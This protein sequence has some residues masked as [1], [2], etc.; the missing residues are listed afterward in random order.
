MFGPSFRIGSIAGIAIEIHP[1]WFLVIGYLTWALAEFV[2]PDFF[3]TWATA[4]YWIIGALTAL[5][6]FVTV[7][8]H[9]LAH[10]LVAKRRGLEVPK[11]SLFIFGGVSHLGGQ[12]RTAGEEFAIAAAGPATSIVIAVAMGVGWL[13][14]HTL[15]EQL[16]AV[17]GY[18]AA[19]NILLA[20]FNMV[21]GLP[22]DGGRVLRSIAW[23]RTRSFRRATRIAAGAGE[24]VG[25][26][27]IAGGVVW[28]LSLNLV[29]IIWILMGWFLLGAARAES[30]AVQM[31]TLL[32]RL[33]A[34]DVMQEGFP[35]VT[36]GLAV[37]EVVDDQMVGRG[38]RAIMVAND[39][40]VVGIITVTDVGRVPRSDW[41]MTPAQRVMTPRSEI[42]TV[43][44]TTPA[45]DVMQVLGQKRL[46]QV[47]VLEDGR[48]IGLIT[49]REFMDRIRLAEA[50]QRDEERPEGGDEPP[51]IRMGGDGFR[52]R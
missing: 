3:E 28:L 39:G 13:L 14:F 50:L 31:D 20:A 41:S 42:V 26:L 7:L 36:P 17:L 48:M 51:P 10:A 37:Q 23:N 46:N 33:T 47:P 43:E 32:G 19:I 18:L 40:Y 2:F 34:R 52:D 1:S 9:E 45:L 15:S 8:V 44:A 35:T 4:T 38:E 12:P 29:G 30:Q 5:L 6:L 21:P 27:M 11:I 49:R 25:W 22:L 16:A 24:V